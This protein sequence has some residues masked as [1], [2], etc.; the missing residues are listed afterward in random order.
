MGIF[1]QLLGGALG[2]FSANKA[3]RQAKQDALNKFVDLR[4]AADAGGI[5]MLTALGATGGSGFGN[6]GGAPPLA[7][8]ELL[9]GAA[10]DIEDEANGTAA[11]RRATERLNYDLAK[12][13][14]DQARSG[15]YDAPA[16]K[17]YAAAGSTVFADN[18]ARP[19]PAGHVKTSGGSNGPFSPALGSVPV[20]DRFLDRASGVFVNGSYIDP[21]P[22]WSDAQT[23][24]DNYGELGGAVYGVAK[25]GH[26]MSRATSQWLADRRRF[27]AV[28]DNISPKP[29]NF[30]SYGVGRSPFEAA[31][32]YREPS[33][34]SR[35]NSP[36]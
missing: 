19:Y 11:Q 16:P 17:S 20:P 4:A 30:K 29:E 27:N 31:R 23:V 32:K 8:V 15:V 14:L 36:W 10:G 26:D 9:T 13:R 6:Y 33:A 25:F 21:S 24:E 1:S 2:I 22:G 28:I 12:I 34:A 35:P 5:S 18:T 7:S 3:R